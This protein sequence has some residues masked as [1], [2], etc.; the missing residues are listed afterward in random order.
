MDRIKPEAEGLTGWGFQEIGWLL[1]EV[2][3]DGLK[4]HSRYFPASAGPD[5]YEAAR[6]A[7]DELGRRISFSFTL[8][9]THLD[10]TSNARPK[11]R[12]SSAGRISSQISRIVRAINDDPALKS[13]MST[14]LAKQ[15][16]I[17]GG[18]LI[19][20]GIDDYI[21]AIKTL[22][23]AATAISSTNGNKSAPLSLGQRAQELFFQSLAK[24]FNECL[25]PLPDQWATAS[26]HDPR[27]PWIVFIRAAYRLAGETTPSV[28][29]LEAAMA[30]ARRFRGSVEG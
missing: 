18:P 28:S 5:S 1:A 21:L 12:A 2:E 25:K 13:L 17:R 22:Q 23:L 6:L 16:S 7:R 30:V 9:N 15:S 10:M 19:G 26:Y 8:K 27:G 24:T 3:R 11:N 29:A 20:F 4:I 14:E